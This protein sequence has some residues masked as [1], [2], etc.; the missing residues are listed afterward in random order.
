MSAP[1]SASAYAMAWPIPRVPPVTMAVLPSREKRAG[2]DI[3]G[4][5]FVGW[6]VVCFGFRIIRQGRGVEWT[7]SSCS[8]INC[9]DINACE[10]TTAVS[11]SQRYFTTI[12]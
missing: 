1:A 12:D 11:I 4:L 5:L 10:S 9:S 8:L 3:F 7:R 2:M 6:V